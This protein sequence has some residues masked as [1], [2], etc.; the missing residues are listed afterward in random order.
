MRYAASLTQDTASDRMVDWITTG[1]A[2]AQSIGKAS[3]EYT[4]ARQVAR[5]AA[6]RDWIEGDSFASALMAEVTSMAQGAQP[7]ASLP[8]FRTWS[9][10]RAWVGVINGRATVFMTAAEIGDRVT[11]RWPFVPGAPPPPSTARQTKLALERVQGEVQQAGWEMACKQ[12]NNGNN[13]YWAFRLP[14]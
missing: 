2:I 4:N 8:G 1:E 13:T 3:G 6:A 11:K 7:S 9:S 10:A 12:A 5:Q 14:K